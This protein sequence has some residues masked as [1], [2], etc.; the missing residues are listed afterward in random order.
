MPPCRYCSARP[1]ISVS[2]VC[3]DLLGDEPARIPGEICQQ[4]RREQRENCQIDQRQLERGRAEKLAERRHATHAVV[5]AACGTTTSFAVADHI[6]GAAHRVQQR[7][8]KALS[9][10]ERNREMCTSMTLVCGSK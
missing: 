3:G 10:F 7:L 5:T 9:I 4:E 2:T 6:A 1:V 8:G